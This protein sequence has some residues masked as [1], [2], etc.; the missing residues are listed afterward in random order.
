MP[1]PVVLAMSVVAWSWG[2]YSTSTLILLTFHAL[3]RPGEAASLLRLHVRLP[4]EF[5]PGGKRGVIALTQTKTSTRAAQIQSVVLTD[6]LILE[7]A[8]LVFGALPGRN[9]LCPGGKK[10]FDKRCPAVA[11]HLKVGH[12]FSPACLR[13]GGAV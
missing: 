3:L 10:G 6:P 2:W 12:L 7:L 13:G 8:S 11:R 1:V 9:L 4:F 5:D